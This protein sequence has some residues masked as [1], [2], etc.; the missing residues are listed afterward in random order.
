MECLS[1]PYDPDVFGEQ[2]SVTRHRGK[3]R[4]IN[5]N[6]SDEIMLLQSWKYWQARGMESPFHRSKKDIRPLIA[7]PEL[8]SQLQVPAPIAE[9]EEAVIIAPPK[10]VLGK[11]RANSRKKILE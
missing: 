7:E 10:E 6:T 1:R 2:Y 8:R 9:I 4:V 5:M 11:P 3:T